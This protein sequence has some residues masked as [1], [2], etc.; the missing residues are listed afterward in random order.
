MRTRIIRAGR[1]CP[2]ISRLGSLSQLSGGEAVGLATALHTQESATIKTPRAKEKTTTVTAMGKRLPSGAQHRKKPLPR[3][4]H[5]TQLPVATDCFRRL[6][7]GVLPS[8]LQ[9]LRGISVVVRSGNATGRVSVQ[10]R[11]AVCARKPMRTTPARKRT[12][13]GGRR[14]TGRQTEAPGEKSTSRR[15]ERA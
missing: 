12:A 1:H 11:A 8:L 4:A 14:K 13:G 2:A 6:L 9:I 5:T 10:K 15:G 3:P 7:S